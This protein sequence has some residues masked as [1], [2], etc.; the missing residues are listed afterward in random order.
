MVILELSRVSVLKIIGNVCFLMAVT[1]RLRTNELQGLC[2]WNTR[3]TLV[4]LGLLILLQ[5][6][7]LDSYVTLGI[8]LSLS[9]P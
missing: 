6:L 2:V 8:W 3:G 1:H 5:C 7:T 9:V 4:R